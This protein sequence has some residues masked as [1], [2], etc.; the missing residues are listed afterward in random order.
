MERV[1]ENAERCGYDPDSIDFSD[2]NI[3]KVMIETPEG[4]IR[5]FGRVGYNDFHIW[6]HLEE[7]KEVPSGTAQQKRERFWK[8]HSKMKGDWKADDY[9][10]NWLSMRLLW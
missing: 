4:Q 3:H 10:P 2:D 5:R 1:L 6:S 9:S 7:Q 8:S